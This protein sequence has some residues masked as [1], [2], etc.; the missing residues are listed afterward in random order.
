MSILNRFFK[1]QRP[2][3][4]EEKS[5]PDILRLKTFLGQMQNLL[6]KDQFLARSDYKNLIVSFE[7]LH[8]KF[9]TL[10]RSE[11]LDYFCK[12]K[13]I[14]KKQVQS[15]LSYYEDL[16]NDDGSSIVNKHN[17]TFVKKHLVED[18]NYL[19]QILSDVDPVIKLDDEQRRVVLSDEDYTLVI[20]GAGAGKT[21]TVAAKVKYLVEKKRVEPDQI[22]VISFTNKAVGELKDKINK[23]LKINCPVT[24]FHK[25]GYAIL[26]KQESE[27][28][29]IVDQG[30]MFNVINNYISGNI[31]ENPE[32][33]DKLILFFGSYFDAPYEGKDLNDFF[34]Y[35]TKA[36]FS[37]LRGNMA[38]YAEQMIDKR[39][40]KCTSIAHETLRSAQEVSIA[41]FL[42]MNGIDYIYEKPYQYNIIR[43]HKP[44]TPDFY[45][46]QGEKT[47]Y[48]EHF[49]ITQ[50]GKNKR[51][52]AE[53]L[54]RYKKEINDKIKLHRKHNTDLTTP[55]QPMMMAGTS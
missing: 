34:N 42:Y 12:N 1:L 15:F 54:N 25:T 45:I 19:D 20:A 14:P 48:I 13:K 21:T 31:L 29:I 26:R 52:S 17:D 47:A 41:N 30:F 44:Y 11:T 43:S 6:S 4:R 53:Q 35:I 28:K 22:L 8:S 10:E 39:T 33:V 36:D 9:K 38:D 32:L 27:R 23:A 7:D 24:T 46:M 2:Q 18:K 50:E 3:V 5:S 49:G 37:T 40:G 55:F 16:K 51:Y